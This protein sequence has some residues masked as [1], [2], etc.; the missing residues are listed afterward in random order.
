MT[1]SLATK[2]MIGRTLSTQIRSIAS[3]VPRRPCASCGEV[4]GGLQYRVQQRT[5]AREALRASRDSAES[6]STLPTSN[7]T[8]RSKE[9]TE[10]DAP[11]RLKS[12]LRTL[13]REVAQ[14]VAVV[15]SFMP[16]GHSPSHTHPAAAHTHSHIPLHSHRH[17]EQNLNFHGAT[18]SS[19]SS[20][21]MDPHPLVAFALRVPSRMAAT[22]SALVPTTLTPSTS[23]SHKN[24]ESR[25]HQTHTQ[26]PRP[27]GHLDTHLVLN[28]L[29]ETQHP[30]AH[31]FSRPDLHPHPFTTA[32]YT[33][34]VDGLPVLDGSLGAL[35]CRVVGRV[36][37]SELESAHEDSGVEGEVLGRKSGG[38]GVVSEL[39]IA[40]V[41]RV[42]R[43][44]VPEEPKE[45]EAPDPLLYWRRGYTSCRSS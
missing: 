29:S 10:P 38:T 15:T 17:H 21:A 40:R 24:T 33:L 2:R 32:P 6:G 25:H 43:V 20:I 18:L 28:I 45:G 13:L 9:Q 31:A 4:R 12:D 1:P 3:T 8:A 23:S 44:G 11:D 34:N 16:P 26:S 7:V 41:I 39:F 36:K 14:P 27:S 5:F 22:L 35:A 30:L 42:E 19:F 37:L